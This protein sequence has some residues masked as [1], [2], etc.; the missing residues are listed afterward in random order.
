M[1]KGRGVKSVNRKSVIEINV[2]AA[3]MQHPRLAI[4]ALRIGVSV[5]CEMAAQCH[6]TLAL[7]LFLSPDVRPIE[8]K[9]LI[10]AD[11]TLVI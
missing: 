5:C 7:V 4:E 9:C 3:T 1:S 8:Y 6:L 2:N 11:L 10:D